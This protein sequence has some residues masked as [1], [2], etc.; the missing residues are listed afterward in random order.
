[1]SD[2]EV[3]EGVL[4]ELR[5]DSRL[6]ETRVEVTVREGFV[7]L[8]GTVAGSSELLAAYESAERSP[9][10]YEIASELRLNPYDGRARTD[11]DIAEAVRGALGR[12][13][14]IPHEH[15]QVAVSNG[16]VA[17]HGKVGLPEDRENVERLV[18]SLEG[19]RGVYNLVEADSGL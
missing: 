4:R 9:G 2:A 18:R 19:V 1:M 6:K 11:A 8:A 5:M 17:L 3:R 7:T 16:W 12:G 13:T 15:I 10:V 14:Q